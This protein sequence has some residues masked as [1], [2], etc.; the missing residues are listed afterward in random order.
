M[1]RRSFLT[2]LPTTAATIGFASE[3]STANEDVGAG[4]EGAVLALKGWIDALA[5]R[6]F[7]FLEQHLAS[8]FVFTTAPMKTANGTIINVQ[9]DKKAFI[10]QDRHVYRSNIQFLGVTARRMGDLVITVVFAQISEE[11]RGDL[12]PGMPS[13]REMNAFAK[14][15]KLGYASGWREI[16]GRWQCTSHHVLGEVNHA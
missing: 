1:D 9:K 14:D 10:E 16:D 15:K 11:F 13:A 6:D 2:A 3:A 5:R 8:D 7:D 12:G 4:C